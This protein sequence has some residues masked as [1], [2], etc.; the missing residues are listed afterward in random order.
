MQLAQILLPEEL[1]ALVQV[2]IAEKRP[3][4]SF[5]MPAFNEENYIESAVMALSYVARQLRVPYEIIIVN[6]GS[7]DNTLTKVIDYADDDCSVRVI[8]YGKNMGKG[9]AIKTGFCYAKG[10]NVIF[11]DSDLDISPNQI[12]KYLEALKSAGI[13][14]ASKWHPQS[15]VK[16]RSIRRVLS[17]SFNAMVRLLTGVEIMDTQTGLKAV[18]RSALRRT[19]SKLS[20][21]RYA[22]DVELLTIA[23]CEGIAV[24]ELPVELRLPAL[25][26]LNDAFRMFI[27]LLGIAYRLKIRKCY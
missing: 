21:K 1:P 19:F 3:V 25:F 20:V 15:K 6:D 27:D 24:V 18:K 9:Y 7:F 22:Y 14:V 13:V 11:I 5:V 10:D 26:K 16:I 8:S 12:E 17:Q 4:V 23:N 2:E